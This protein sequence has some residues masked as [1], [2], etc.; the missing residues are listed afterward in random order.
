VFGTCLLCSVATGL[1][2]D[3][4]GILLEQT[5]KKADAREQL[6]AQL[7]NEVKPRIEHME[8]ESSAVSKKC[9]EIV[10]LLQVSDDMKTHVAAAQR[11]V[12]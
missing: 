2:S 3:A 7:L 4:W 11:P 6:S 1:L 5:H 9:A 8:R 10:Q 12:P